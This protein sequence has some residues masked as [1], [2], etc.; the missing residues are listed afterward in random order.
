[1]RKILAL[2]A[3]VIAGCGSSEK[4]FTGVPSGGGPG[5]A[6]G[7]GS[8]PPSTGSGG[9]GGTAPGSFGDVT[10]PDPHAAGETAVIYGHSPDT[11]YRLDLG[12]KAVSVVAPFDGCTQVIDIALDQ[13]SNLFATTFFGF[14][15]VDRTTA[16]CTLIKNDRYPNS[17]S[18]VP[19]G[20]LDPSVEALVGYFGSDY[21]RIDTQTGNITTVGSLGGGLS[22][23]GDIVSV[24]G[25]PT[26]LTV[27]G[28][29]CND[30]LAE[31]DPKTGAL[32]K[33][34][35]NV[36]HR[37]VFGI[38]FWAGSVYGFDAGGELFEITIQKSALGTTPIAIPQA[39]AGLQFWGAGSTT[40]A[41][42]TPSNN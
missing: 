39:P 42:V 37:D 4:G 11:L 40:S 33:N 7:N 31:V 21:V 30:C 19:V 34:W 3:L 35:G 14:Y 20:T 27:K 38:A 24:I 22:S 29:N 1:M 6:Q 36:S 23:S 16:K 32:V 18:F 8:P 13:K 26:Y 41:P 28:T 17:L 9:G 25:G 12:S 15:S 2:L 10:P 5:G